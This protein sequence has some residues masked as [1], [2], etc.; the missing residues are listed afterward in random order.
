MLNNRHAYF[1]LVD[2]GTQ[3][4]YGAELILRRKL[5]K[6]ISNLKLHPCEYEFYVYTYSLFKQ[7]ISYTNNNYIFYCK[8][9]KH[10]IFVKYIILFFKKNFKWYIIKVKHLKPYGRRILVYIYFIAHFIKKQSF[11]Y[12]FFILLMIHYYR[13]K[14]ELLP[15][16]IMII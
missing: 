8:S 4:K 9:F 1:L 2:N 5:E 10:F 16:C 13:V 15:Y 7:I 14:W 3:G 6:F 11:I 12:L